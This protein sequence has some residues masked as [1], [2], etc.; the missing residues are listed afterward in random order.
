[1]IV[2]MGVGGQNWP[3]ALA[4][5]LIFFIAACSS[6][7][8]QPSASPRIDR[9]PASVAPIAPSGASDL[10]KDAIVTLARAGVSPEEV[11]EAWRRD[12]ARLKLKAADI[13]DLHARGVS[14]TILDALL[15]AQE[16]ALR[17]DFDSRLA[18]Q[19]AVA[20]QQLAAERARTP[21]CPAP[22]YWGP[23]PYGGW[24]P[25]GWWGGATWGW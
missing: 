23:R 5:S 16:L 17:I 9:L 22:P 3:A 6:S 24:G 10:S 15:D 21:V 18:A 8:P 4:C 11:V 19:Q 25:G 7:G 14:P 12:G 2:Q 20:E 13:V 1:M